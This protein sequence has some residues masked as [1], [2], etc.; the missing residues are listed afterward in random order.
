MGAV[1]VVLLKKVMYEMEELSQA[2]ILAH[3]VL[4]KVNLQTMAKIHEKSNEETG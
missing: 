2:T 3:F 1:K 4:L